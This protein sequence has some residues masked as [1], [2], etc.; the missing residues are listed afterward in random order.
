MK[1]LFVVG[2]TPHYYNLLLNKLN[3]N[4]EVEVIVVA[5]AGNGKTVGTGVHQSQEGIEFK[6]HYLEEYKTYYG[7]MFFKNI[8]QVIDNEQP[9]IIVS[10]WPYQLAWVFFPFL[11]WKIRRRNIKLMSKEIPFQIPYYENAIEFYKN[12]GG[13]TETNQTIHQKTGLLFS[14]K[15][16]FITEI[17]KIMVNTM[18]AHINYFDEA[19]A[20]QKSYGVPEK[21]VFITSN[22]P[23]TDYILEVKRKIISTEKILPENPY[24][25]IHVGRL[26]KWKRVDLII[27]AAKKLAVKYPEI[28]L[29]IVGNGPEEQNLKQQATELGIEKHIHFVGG[30]YDMEVLGKY[31]LAS[32]IYIL[33][34]MGGLSINEAMCFGL[35]VICSVADGTEKILVREGKNGHFFENGNLESL[36]FIIDKML[37]NLPKIEQMGIASENIIIN[38]ININTVL[39]KYIEALNFVLKKS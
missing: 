2:A 9:N 8:S 15:Y 35:P 38:E 1:V 21:K 36:V 22:S 13:I 4:S 29:V 26:V 11:L 34:G 6:I 39:A 32:N 10:N 12:G 33:A 23:D 16:W 3:Q 14:L 7:K 18:D 17:R 19:V 31:Y 28:E 20:I 27:S 24:R 5:P 37:A 30:I 25:I